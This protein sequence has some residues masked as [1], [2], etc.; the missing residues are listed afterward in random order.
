ML[1]R[2]RADASSNMTFR[3]YLSVLLLLCASAGSMAAELPACD[4]MAA[5]LRALQ[6]LE[7]AGTNPLALES[8]RY[9]EQAL[10]RSLDELKAI[11]RLENQ[12]DLHG[13]VLAA[14]RD[15]RQ[16]N[17][18]AFQHSLGE[19]LRLFLPIYRRMCGDG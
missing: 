19:I 8:D 7:S 18:E 2:K 1:T 12:R 4:D 3:R 17:W 5:I 9:A 15:W 16:S 6:G 14:E 13:S 11:A 10:G